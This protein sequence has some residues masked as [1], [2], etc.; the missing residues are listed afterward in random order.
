LLLTPGFVT[1]VVGFLCL[2]PFTRKRFTK[3]VMSRFTMVAMSQQQNGENPETP[4][5][6]RARPL[7]SQEKGQEGDVIDGDFRRED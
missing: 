2:I 6:H 4:F 7:H 3:L 5:V 1:D